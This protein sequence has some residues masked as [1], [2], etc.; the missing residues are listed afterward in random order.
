MKATGIVRNVDSV[1]RLVLPSELREKFG[2]KE[3]GGALE[4]YVEDDSI[5]LKKYEPTCIFCGGLDGILTYKQRNICKSCIDKLAIV[6]E[7][8]RLL[9]E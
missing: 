7:N 4:V 3:S 5:I 6:K 9:D 1:G 8:A 2:I